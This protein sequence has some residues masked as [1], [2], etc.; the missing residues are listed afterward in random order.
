MKKQTSP[1]FNQNTRIDGTETYLELVQKMSGG[2][3][4]AFNFLIMLI[5]TDRLT[6]I[7]TLDQIG[8][9]DEDIYYLWNDCCKC[10]IDTFNLV[11]AN[12][13][14]GEISPTEVLSKVKSC[15]EFTN[16]KSLDKLRE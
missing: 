15:S 1:R 7:M 11:I 3:I 6:S 9:Y 8:I 2:N 13:N 4:G 10:N 14:Y 16:L 12:C 5:S